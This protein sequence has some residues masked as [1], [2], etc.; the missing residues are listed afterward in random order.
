MTVKIKVIRLTDSDWGP[1]STLSA[2]YS[3]QLD[4]TRSSGAGWDNPPSTNLTSSSGGGFRIIESSA[5]NGVVS[6]TIRVVLKAR[7][8]RQPDG[9]NPLETGGSTPTS[10]SYFKQPFFG[11]SSVSISGPV[12]VVGVGTVADS[13]SLQSYFDVTAPEGPYKSYFLNATSNRFAAIDSGATL[14]G[15]VSIFS[16]GSGAN[17]VL[18]APGGTIEG[19]V[20]AAGDLDSTVKSYTE[21]GNVLARADSP[22]GQYEPSAPRNGPN[23]TP[24]NKN[25]ATNQ[26][27]VAPLATPSSSVEL[28]S[29]SEYTDAGTSPTTGGETVF[30]TSTLS[31]DGIP[32]GKSVTFDNASSSV[33]IYVDQGGS[34]LNAVK[35]DSSKI[36]TTSKSPQNFQI[37]YE[38][39]KPVIV[40]LTNDFY[41]LV[42]APNA[43]VTLTGNGNYE[44]AL[45]GKDLNIA[46]QSGSVKIYTDLSSANSGSNVGN[47]LNYKLRAGEGS[48]IQGWQPVTWQEFASRP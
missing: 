37:W 23:L 30:Q 22:E 4:P 3:P 39:N 42:Y 19:T 34:Q 24:I 11:N 28:A 21:A 15:N 18:T 1:L 31:T 43:A 47:G 48:V 7:F 36:T 12:K 40:N 17:T 44:G 38:G 2:V 27:Q 10:Q 5:T 14:T 16:R 20:T 25:S 35:I 29:L 41:G 8:D 13:T 45:V 33:K 6:R 32:N 26:Y 9:S 46:M